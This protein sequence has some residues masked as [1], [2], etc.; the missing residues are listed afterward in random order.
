[1]GVEYDKIFIDF[2]VNPLYNMSFANIFSHSTGCL[3]V[4]LIVSFAVQK[5]SIFFKIF[6]YV[7]ILFLRETDIQSAS[8]GGAQR[9]GDT[10]SEAGSRL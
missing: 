6:S 5:L 1:M 9:E 4:L 3:L 7:F 10:E 8:G 2:D